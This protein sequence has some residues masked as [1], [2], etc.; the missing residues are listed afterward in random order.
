M[1]EALSPTT[2]QTVDRVAQRALALPVLLFLTAHSPLRFFAGQMLVAAAPLADLMGIDA[3]AEW[4][5]ILN[6]P[7]A[8]KAV[9]NAL[10]KAAS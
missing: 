7:D 6:D 2:Q 3:V 9:Q 8:V 4:A 10:E 5:T 1:S